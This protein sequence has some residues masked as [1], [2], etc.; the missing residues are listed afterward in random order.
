LFIRKLTD[1]LHKQLR[2]NSEVNLLHPDVR[3]LLEMEPTFLAALEETLAAPKLHVPEQHLAEVA[4]TSMIERVHTINQFIQVDRRAKETLKGLYL[5]TWEIMLATNDIE[6]S[7]RNFHFPLLAEWVDALYPES[8]K[9][10]LSSSF[11]IGKVSCQ[12]Y[13]ADLQVGLLKLEMNDLKQPV[14]D[15][16]CGKEAQL[17]EH[18]RSKNVEAFGVDRSVQ[19]NRDYL[20]KK[21]WL[22]TTFEVNRW[23][24]VI[25]H[26][27]FSNHFIYIEK[28]DSRCVPLYLSKYHEILNSLQLKGSFVYTPG[29]LALERPVDRSR[30]SVERFPIGNGYGVTRVSKFAP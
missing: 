3:Q 6:N 2:L 10:A 29:C 12:D 21:D 8:L 17:V 18:L 25:S 27:A 26:M 16:G 9:T 23:G 13:S 1:A 24:T 5:R 20:M 28:F 19:R 4:A 11:K 22:E 30:Y 7:L 15:I 14:L